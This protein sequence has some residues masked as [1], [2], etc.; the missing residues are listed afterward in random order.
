MIAK[1]VNTL[2]KNILYTERGKIILSIILGLGL[3]TL[4]RKFCEGKNCYSFIGPEQKN[5]TNQIYSFDSKN[6]T[7]YTMK[8]KNI[9]CGNKEQSLYFA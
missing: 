4:F 8:E 2:I 3:A 5:V 9:K 6:N 7:C 1:G